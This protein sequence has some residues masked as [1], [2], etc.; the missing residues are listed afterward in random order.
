M[1]DKKLRIACKE[2]NF[3]KIEWLLKEEFADASSGLEGACEGGHVDIAQMMIDRDANLEHGLLGAC[4]GGHTDLIQFIIEKGRADED[5]DLIDAVNSG[6]HGACEGGHKDLVQLMIDMGATCF[7]WG[8][9]GACEGGHTDLAQMMIDKGADDIEQGLQYACNGGHANTVQLMIDKAVTGNYDL[10]KVFN[11]GLYGACYGGNEE[12]AQMMIDKGAND[13]SLYSACWGGNLKIVQLMINYGANDWDFGLYAASTNCQKYV[14]RFM[15]INGAPWCTDYR[16]IH[17]NKRFLLQVFA[18]LPK[19]YR[20]KFET[21]IRQPSDYGR[22]RLL[23]FYFINRHA[24]DNIRGID[25]FQSKVWQIIQQFTCNDVA[26]F[27]MRFVGV[28]K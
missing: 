9:F 23:L 22:I 4:K 16:L 19:K 13:F 26:T 1:A 3:P 27:V 2:R 21:K 6:L 24:I 10:K 5:F 8:L 15:I 17:T 12:L 25:L 28:S 18:I 20:K 14:A 11:Y 7:H